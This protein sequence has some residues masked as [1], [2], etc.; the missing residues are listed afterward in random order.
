MIELKILFIFFL[1]YYL[2]SN[3]EQFVSLDTMKKIEKN[4][5][6]FSQNVPYTKARHGICGSKKC[7]DIVDHYK[8]AEMYSNDP[9]N[10]TLANLKKELRY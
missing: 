7:I 3:S 2:C 9:N 4:K 8:I 5:N 10:I 1:I 6:L